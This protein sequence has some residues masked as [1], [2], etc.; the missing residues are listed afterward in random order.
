ME[1]RKLISFGKS[2]YVVSLPKAWVTQ[3]K[4]KKGDLIYL[5]ENKNGLTLQANQQSNEEKEKKISIPIDGKDL[6]RIQRETISA[7]INNYKTITFFGGEIKSKASEIQD[8][9]QR[10]VALEIVEQDSKK[11]VAKDF[12]NLKDISV[13]QIIKKMD[14]IS[15]SMLGDCK[16]MFKEDNFESIYHRDFDLNKFRFLIYRIVRYGMENPAGVLKNFNLTSLDLF[17]YWWLSFSIEQ[18]GDCIKRIARYMKEVEFSDKNKKEYTL[19]LE[20]IEKS[21]LAI[22]KAYYNR[23]IDMAHQILNERGELIDKCD[24]FFVR[25]KDSPVI[26]YLVY[27][28]KALIVNV[29]AVARTIYQGMPVA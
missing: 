5:D 11:I 9:I 14:V 6:K 7:Y 17:N 16:K 3:N 25:N 12:L 15:R 18:V 2:S 4:L 28:T 29:N 8:F 21:Y 27:N 24:D 23:D 1:Y 10:L 26:G 22:L 20:N 19:L 13:E